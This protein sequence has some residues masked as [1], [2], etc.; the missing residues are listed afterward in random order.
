[1]YRTDANH[2]EIKKALLAAGC[3][4]FD[5][6]RVGSGFPD[7]MVRRRGGPVVLLEVKDGT[8]PPSRRGLTLPEQAFQAMWG[9]AYHVVL[10]VEQALQ[11]VGL[12]PTE[13]QKKEQREALAW[14]DWRDSLARG[15]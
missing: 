3:T 12:L 10:T 15:K 7:L 11:A 2:G 4:V 13:A 14:D 8:L 6:A 9:D 1:M 5:G